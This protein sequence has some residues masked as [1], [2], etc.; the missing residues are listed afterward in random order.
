MSGTAQKTVPIE[1][2]AVQRIPVGI[3]FHCCSIDCFGT[4]MNMSEGGMF[5][6]S[7]KIQF[8]IET[9]FKI[10]IPLKDNLLS[11]HVKINRMTKTNGYYDGIGIEIVNPSQKYLNYISTLVA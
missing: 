4:I 8:P 5:L 11:V 1:K 6:R 7:K 3:E 10:F 2:R 9:Q